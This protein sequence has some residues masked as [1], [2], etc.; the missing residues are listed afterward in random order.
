[1][2]VYVVVSVFLYPR[3]WLIMYLRLSVVVCVASLFLTVHVCVFA[4]VS[5][6]GV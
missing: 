2:P 1:M 4:S 6:T 5:V 3:L